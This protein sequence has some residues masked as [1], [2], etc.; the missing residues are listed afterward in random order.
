MSL[1]EEERVAVVS[2][3]IEKAQ[4]AIDEAEKVSAIGLWNIAANRLYYALFHAVSAML[5]LDHHEIGIHRGAVNRFSMYYVKTGLF[6]K[7]E[8]RLYSQLQ[9]LREDGDY[10]CSFD[11]EQDEVEHYIQPTLTLID[12]IKQYIE[13]TQSKV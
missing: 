12:K 3:R 1:S 8:G 5:I 10:N 13:N 9:S 4:N 11:V 6:S 2:Y 7:Q